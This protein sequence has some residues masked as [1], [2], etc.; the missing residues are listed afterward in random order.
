M[1]TREQGCFVRLCLSEFQQ[2]LSEPEPLVERQISLDYDLRTCHGLLN[3]LQGSSE[4]VNIANHVEHF[5]DAG[6]ERYS[7]EEV[8]D[9]A[10]L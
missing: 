3:Y 8:V 1:V 2:L 6:R 9:L 10:R 7:I 5:C 4:A